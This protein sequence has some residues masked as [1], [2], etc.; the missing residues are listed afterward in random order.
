MHNLPSPYLLF[1]GDVVDEAFAKTAFGLRDWAADKCIGEFACTDGGLTLGLPF[2]T[3]TEAAAAG[4]RAMVIGI[5]NA[6]GF[7]APSWIASLVMALE[8]GLDLVSGLHVPLESQPEL[9][10]AAERTGRKLI[11]VRRPQADISVASG[12]RRRGRRA[13]TVGTDCAVG[14]K[15]TALAV[16]RRLNE[17]GVAADFRATGQTG[18]L[19]AAS[20]VPLDAV[21]SD[22][23][24]GAAEQLSPDASPDHWDI[25]EGQGSLMH[26]AYGGVSLA[27]LQGS[28]PDAII[29][30]HDPMRP[31]LLGR[32]GFA[33]P[34]V[35]EIAA[36][37]LRLGASTNPDMRWTGVA[38]N[39]SAMS[40]EAAERFMEEESYRLGLPVADPLR[41]GHRFERLVASLLQ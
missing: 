35:D 1:L 15:Y 39:T 13:L 21:I 34:N 29:V 3:P 30:C 31:N 22:F 11:E 25:I 27:L 6:G 17:L 7:I 10:A 14:K 2:L 33:V 32:P 41:G 38:L 8:A 20:G 24:A 19:I 23:A 18:I 36:L 5:A 28:Q 40:A 16:A 26:P 4:A 37:S 9:K 12:T